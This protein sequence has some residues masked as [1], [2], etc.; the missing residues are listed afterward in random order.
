MHLKPGIIKTYSLEQGLPHFLMLSIHQD[1]GGTIWA[2]TN[3]K[4]IAY[5]QE[6]RFKPF[7]LIK[8]RYIWSIY[9]DRQGTHWF[10][11]YDSGLYRVREGRVKNFRL[12][13]GLPG[14]CIIALYEDSKGNLWVGSADGGPC[15]YKDGIFIPLGKSRGF[16][17]ESAIAFLED[18]RGAVWVGTAGSGLNRYKDGRFINYSR[19]DGLSENHV[20]ALYEDDQGALWIGTYGGGLNRWKNRK[21]TAVTREHGLYNNVV[22]SILEDDY[23]Y[24]WMTCNRGVYRVKKKE[25][26]EFADGKISKFH[27]IFYNKADGMLSAE[28]NGGFQPSAIKTGDGKLWIPTVRGIA[29]FDPSRARIN[30]LPPPVVIEKMIIDDKSMDSPGFMEIPAGSKSLE[31]HY[32][33]LS[34]LNPRF[35]RFKYKLEP[36]ERQWK[37]VDTRRTA[38]YTKLSPGRYTFRVIACNNDGIWNRTGASLSFYLKP[39]FYQTWWFY[40][41]CGLGLLGMVVLLFYLRD[42]HLKKRERVLEQQV[43]QRTLELQKAREAAEEAN[44]SKSEFLARMS[45]EIRT[46]M[47]SVIGFSQLLAE[48]GLDEIQEDYANTIVSSGEALLSI[49]DDILDLSKIESGIISF[50]PL[51]FDPEVTAFDVCESILPRI[52]S[53]PVEV[54]CRIGDRVPA[55]VRQDP[56]RFRQVLVNLMGNAAK[57]TEKGEIELSMDV[58]EENEQRLKLHCRVR[59]TGIGIPEDRLDSIFDAFRQVDG[60]ITRKF[61]GTGLG[62]AICKKIAR[63]MSGDIRAESTPGKGSVFHFTAWVDKS[64]KKSHEKSSA[65]NLAGKRVLIVDD[66]INNLDILEH[67]LEKR[68]MSV[69]KETAAENIESLLREYLKNGTPF[70]LCILDVMIPGTTGPQLAAKIRQLPPPLGN[71]PLLALTSVGGRHWKEYRDAGFDGLLPKPVQTAKLLQMIKGLLYPSASGPPEKKTQ[72][73]EKKEII[74]QYSLSEEIKH[75]VRILLVEDNSVNRKLIHFMLGQAGYQVSF[76]ENG[77]EAVEKYISAPD[78]FDLIFM[79]IHMPGMDGREAT[80]NIRRKGFGDVPII[81]MTAESLEGD[82]EKC[83]KAGMND[84]ISKPIKREVVFEMIKKWILPR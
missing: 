25:L 4:G 77:Q 21:F 40:L 43:A 26:Q 73:K 1:N 36:F 57:F 68:G 33:A 28:C 39:A 83:L 23:G 9:T 67:I 65:A 69:V 66:N 15:I 63:H 17:G 22:S 84:Y 58:D 5:L 59:D 20:R 71:I 46:P 29:V 34:F 56:G 41:L 31:F 53:R 49:I 45:H 60:S 48:T 81:A 50:D 2:G 76:A 54:L 27:C 3:G 6:G 82:R 11:S 37:D 24:F 8:D 51:D 16:V 18:S 61:G 44:R 30:N 52:G 79:D 78:T 74:T 35:V 64:E 19:K 47:N 32:T 70:H 12:K 14:E 7:T 42:R 55:F 13:D 38:Y 80:R 72:K 75:S 10:G 62:L